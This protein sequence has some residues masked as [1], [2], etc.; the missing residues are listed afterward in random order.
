M[1]NIKSLT[2]SETAFISSPI[3]INP[4]RSVL[5]KELFQSSVSTKSNYLFP[6][7]SASG[8]GFSLQDSYL[9]TLGEYCER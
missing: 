8:I 9:F 6:S 7:L 4:N 3:Y 1:I 5:P 2:S